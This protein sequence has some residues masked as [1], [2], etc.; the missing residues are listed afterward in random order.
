ME[1]EPQVVLPGT[2]LITYVPWECH[3]IFLQSRSLNRLAN[4]CRQAV[5]TTTNAVEAAW[6][7][8]HVPAASLVNISRSENHVAAFHRRI[9]GVLM[10]VRDKDPDFP[11]IDVDNLLE[12]RS[13]EGASILSVT[14]NPDAG[15]SHSA[16]HWRLDEAAHVPFADEIYEGAAPTIAQ[17]GGRVTLFSTPNGRGN[18]FHRIAESPDD[19]GFEVMQFPWWWVPTYNPKYQEWLAAHKAGDGKLQKQLIELA[20]QGP[21]YSRM[22]KQFSKASFEREFECSFDADAGA[23]FTPAQIERT[24]KRNWISEQADPLGVCELLYRDKADQDH[25]Y[26]SAADPGRKQDATAVATFDADISPAPLVEYKR[27]E[28]GTSDWAMIEQTIRETA[29]FW[30]PDMLIE[31]NGVGDPIAEMLSDV[32]EPYTMSSNQQNQAKYA[33]IENLRRAMDHGAIVL[34][35]IPQLLQEFQRYKWNDKGLVTDSVM[36]IA[37][38]VS[39]FYRPDDVFLG[40]DSNFSYVEG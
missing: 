32:A 8:I 31:S 4:K 22:R 18:L 40:A 38:A 20:K 13:A 35:R 6:E 19:F 33:L 27:V 15:R 30:E 1:Y 14:A 26:A 28:P 21:W 29:Q 11:N 23:V 39:I 25:H 12:T 37:M 10:S 16:T 34:P 9:R 36:A 17:T 7:F 5:F 3:Q 2:G 24:F